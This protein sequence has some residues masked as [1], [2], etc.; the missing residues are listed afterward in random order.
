MLGSLA[1]DAPHAM[2]AVP[3][4][5]ATV[6]AGGCAASPLPLDATCSGA[7]RRLFRA[8][9]A[10]VGLPAESIYDGSTMASE[11][12]ANSMHAQTGIQFDVRGCAVAGAPEIWLYLRRVGGEQ[13]LVCKVFD[14]LPR[15][16]DDAPPDPAVRR[17]RGRGERAR[18]ARDRRPVPGP[19]GPSSDPGPAGGLEGLRQGGLVRAAGPRQQC[20]GPVPRAQPGSVQAAGILERMLSERGIGHIV[21]A[22]APAS[23]MS[24]LSIRRGLTVWC[25]SRV[26][27]WTGR[28]G[29]REWRAFSDLVDAAEQIVCAYEEL[30][31]ADA[32]VARRP[33]DPAC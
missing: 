3:A 28:T 30:G 2:A 10:G 4:P 22:D 32:G 1:A 7:A 11:L 23:G 15:W 29:R 9:A 6:S 8:A 17:A 21:R 20:P 14:A 25:R 27:S 12:A 16:K 13:E 33:A 18:A 26:V 19:L 24:V 31:S 5:A